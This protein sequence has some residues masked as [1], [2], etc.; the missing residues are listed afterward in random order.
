MSDTF[1]PSASSFARASSRRHR[2]ERSRDHVLVSRQR[3]FDR[4]VLV[5]GLEAQAERTQFLDESQVVLVGEPLGDRLG[6]VGAEAVDLGELLRCRGDQG[7]DVA[8]VAREVLREHPADPGD[9]Q[10]EEHARERHT[11]ADASI[12]SIAFVA[13][14]SA[15]PS[16][17]SSCSFVSR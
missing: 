13:E 7:V 16:S 14:I 9:V 4:T 8:D 10:P 11:C 1:A 3:A 17:S 6:A 15:K 2:L 5:A 12:W